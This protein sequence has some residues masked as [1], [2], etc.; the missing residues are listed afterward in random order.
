MYKG[1]SYRKFRIEKP[2]QRFIDNA[3]IH[4]ARIDQTIAPEKRDP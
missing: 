3:C 1:D 2:F 4:K